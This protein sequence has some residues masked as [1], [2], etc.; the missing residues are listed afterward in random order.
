MP[1]F[2]PAQ[3]AEINS[4]FDLPNTIV[5]SKYTE[6]GF[7]VALATDEEHHNTGKK[8]FGVGMGRLMAWCDCGEKPTVE[9]VIYAFEVFLDK[10]PPVIELTEKE[11]ARRQ[12]V[13]AQRLADLEEEEAQR[14]ADLEEEEFLAEWVIDDSVLA[15]ARAIVV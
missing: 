8:Y 15:E 12:E 13:E 4:H 7:R 10:Y 5:V 11:V 3:L 2:T 6:K 1:E 14:L 9:G